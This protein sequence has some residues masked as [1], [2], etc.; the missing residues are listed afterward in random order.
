VA[1]YLG[2][3]ILKTRCLRCGLHP[4]VCP[5]TRCVSVP[6]TKITAGVTVVRTQATPTISVLR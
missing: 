2:M 6:E 3:C 5:R 1:L 4:S